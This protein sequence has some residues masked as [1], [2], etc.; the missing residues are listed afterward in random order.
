MLAATL[1]AL[2]TMHGVTVTYGTYH[3]VRTL[4]IA[5]KVPAQTSNLARLKRVLDAKRRAAGHLNRAEATALQNL[6]AKQSHVV[7]ST[8]PAHFMRATL[9]ARTGALVRYT[10]IG[11]VVTYEVSRVNAARYGAR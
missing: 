7:K 2:S 6:A 9:D 3:G 11:L 8:I 1:R 5:M 4:E 10:D